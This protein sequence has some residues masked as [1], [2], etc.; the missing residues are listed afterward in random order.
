[1]EKE[2]RKLVR[3]LKANK[4]QIIFDSRPQKI[5]FPHYIGGALEILNC[6]LGVSWK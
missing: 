4:I 1:M 6:R 2:T 5:V 3:E